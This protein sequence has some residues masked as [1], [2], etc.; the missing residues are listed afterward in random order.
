VKVVAVIEDDPSMRTSVARALHA[1]GYICETYESAEDYLDRLAASEANSVL[2]DIHLS[3]LSGIEL[4]KR[5]TESGRVLNVIL[6]TG[7]DIEANEEKA[8]KAG[9]SAYLHKPF[10][11]RSLIDAIEK[12]ESR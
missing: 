5:L 9:S 7:I 6:M 8:I 2:I 11:T 1:S 3:G 4:C 10:S 12:Q